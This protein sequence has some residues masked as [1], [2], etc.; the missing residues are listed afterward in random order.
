MS[1]PDNMAESHPAPGAP[2]ADMAIATPPKEAPP[3][4]IGGPIKRALFSSSPT[5]AHKTNA[6]TPST[7]EKCTTRESHLVIAR[8][9]CITD[10]SESIIANTIKVIGAEP[11]LEAFLTTSPLEMMPTALVKITAKKSLDS[12]KHNDLFL[13][14]EGL[15][16]TQAMLVMPK[17]ACVGTL[18]TLIVH[19][20]DVYQRIHSLTQCAGSC[21]AMVGLPWQKY[22]AG[23]FDTGTAGEFDI[24]FERSVD[25]HKD[26]LKWC[27]DAM[28]LG[29]T[30]WALPHVTNA[31]IMALRTEFISEEADP[32]DKDAQDQQF[33][34]FKQALR[35][36]LQAI[37]V[38]GP[39]RD[40][41]WAV[42]PTDK[43]V[44]LTARGVDL[45]RLPA[46]TKMEMKKLVSTE[47][48][49]ASFEV[50]VAPQAGIFNIKRGFR[51]DGE[52]L[53][54][55]LTELGDDV[56]MVIPRTEMDT[57][58]TGLLKLVLRIKLPAEKLI[59]KKL[60]ALCKD[61]RN[62]AAEVKGI[63]TKLASGAEVRIIWSGDLG[64]ARA[65]NGLNRVAAISAE[66]NTKS[67]EELKKLKGEL[68]KQIKL[69]ADTLVEQD[70]KFT[71]YTV[72]MQELMDKQAT[73]ITDMQN[74]HATAMGDMQRQMGENEAAHAKSLVDTEAAHVKALADTEESF[75]KQMGEMQQVMQQQQQMQLGFTAEAAQ[76][77]QA[78]HAFMGDVK[79][80]M[81]VQRAQ[82]KELKDGS[83]G[84]VEAALALARRQ[85]AV[86]REAMAMHARVTALVTLARAGLPTAAI[87]EAPDFGV[88]CGDDLLLGRDQEDGTISGIR[89]GGCEHAA[90]VTD[91]DVERDS[92]GPVGRATAN[93]RI[94][95]V[96]GATRDRA[97][98]EPLV[99]QGRK[100]TCCI[101]EGR[102]S[103]PGLGGSKV[104]PRVS[105]VAESQRHTASMG[106]LDD[107]PLGG[108]L[109]V[110]SMSMS[111]PLPTI[112]TR[113]AT[114]ALGTAH[115]DGHVKFGNAASSRRAFT[116]IHAMLVVL[117]LLVDRCDAYGST[118]TCCATVDLRWTLDD[119][120]LKCYDTVALQCYGARQGSWLMHTVGTMTQLS[121]S[122]KDIGDAF[123]NC[124]RGRGAMPE[125][126]PEPDVHRQYEPE[127]EPSPRWDSPNQQV[128]PR[129]RARP[130]TDSNGRRG[131]GPLACVWAPRLQR[132]PRPRWTAGMA[133]GIF[134]DSGSS[135]RR[136]RHRW[137]ISRKAWKR[138]MRA[139]RG[140]TVAEMFN[141]ALWNARE[142]H[143]DA[144]P[145]R[146]A[147]RAKALWIMRRLQEEDVDVCFLLEVM[148]SQEAFTAGTFG[149]RAMAK[150]I[151]YVVRWMVG[152]G[153]SQREQRQSGE[154]FTNGI[155]VLVKQAT[156]TIER[157]ARLEERVLGVWIKGR[158]TKEQLQ[159]RIAA[160]HGLHH[161]GASSFTNQL[162]ATYTWAADPSQTVKGCLVVGDFNYVA[163]EAWRSSHAM[164][165]ANDR[166]FRDYISQPGAEYVLPASQP[167]VVWTRKGGDAAE[168]SDSDGFG[169]ML[170]GAVTIGSECGW[171]R[172]T[173]VDFAFNSDGLAT[174]S[175]KPLSDHAWVTFSREIPQLA[176]RG[177][178][179]PRSAL[180]RG[181]I[182]AKDNYR[183]R[184][185]EGVAFE[186]LL[187]ARG[188]LH[189]TT[190]A[191]RSLRRVAE[192]AA[193]EARRR[194][195]EHPLETAHRWRRWLQEA[196]AARHR[197]LAPH[198]VRGG[199]FNY[200]S[201]LWLIRERFEGA[202]DDVCWSKI[203][204][205]CR[206]CWT[207]ANRRLVRRQQRD[208]KRLRELSLGIVEGKGSTDL[209]QVAMR[210]W[211][212]IRPQ[213][214][215]LAFDRFHRRDDVHNAPTL[216]AD[217][218]DAF[219]NSLAR[220]GDRLVE[221]LSSTPAII[222]AFKAFCKVFCPTYET[223]RGRDGG[224]WELSKELTFPVFLQVLKRVPRGKAVGYGGF[225]IEL[226]IHADREIQR[227]FYD[228]LM[229]DLRGGDF[230]PSWR[231]V[232]YVLLT[233][234]PPS[235]PALIS[236]RREIALMAQDMK[237]VMHM[238][239]ATAY[240]LITG[241]LRSEQCGWLPGYG[242]V[243]AG[244]PLAAVIQ[245]AQRLQQSVWILY[246]DLATF[247]PRIDREALTVAEL[248]VGLP[249]QVI[250]LVGQ[251]YGAGRAVAAEAV[252]C[253]FDTSIGLS[254][255]FRNHR[256]AL[257]GEVLSPDRAK[258]ILNSI[259]WAIKLHVHG[260]QLF[261]F[262][263]DE[264][265]CIRA[266][267][268]LAYADDWAGT[269][270]SEVDLKR[271]W[272]IWSVWVP[273]SGS[274]LGIKGKLK[275]VVTG[276][277]RDGQGRESDIPDPQLVT[278][279]GVRV[280]TLSRSEAYKHLGVLRAA[281]GGDEAAADSLKKQL[282]VA[283]GR[284]ARMHKPSRRDMILVS[285][286]LFQGLAG[287]K[288]S[289]VYYPFEWM[290]DI[291]KE[292]RRMF[293]KKAR[294]DA[295]TPV[296][297]L[298]E[299]GGGVAGGR[300]HLW[301][302]GCASFYVSFT[303]ALADAAD[304]SQRAAARSALALSLSRWGVQG[305]PRLFSWRH[306]TSALERHLRGRRRYLGETF[307]F[308]S[309]LLQ[310]D[311]PPG[312]NWRWVRSPASCDPLHEGRPHFRTLES[313][314]L[315]EPEQRGGLGIEP[316]P[317]LLDARI[318]AAGQLYAWGAMHEGSRL[319][320]FEEARRL[321]PWLTAGAR[322]EWDRTVAG[323]EERL[324]VGAVPER[325]A[326]RAWDQRGLCVGGGGVGLDGGERGTVRTDTES[327]HKLHGAIRQ[328]LGELKRG[329]APTPVDWESALRNA[330]PGI[331]GP[332]AEEWCVGGGD[333]Q[334]DARGGR[335]FCDIDCAEEPRGGEA[336]WLRRSDVDG[337]GFLEGWM[338]RACELRSQFS[339]DME[340]YLC[341]R[342][343]RRLDQQQ[344]AQLDPA[345]QIVARARLALGDVEVFSGDGNKRQATH[346]QLAAQRNLWEKL[347]TWSA[348]IKATRIYTLDGG[349]REVKTEGG[350]VKIATRAAIDH[351]G[352][353]M[354]GRICEE[355]VNEDNY[356]AELAA[357]LDAL[358][359]AT[360]RG[361]DERVIMVFDATSPVRAMLRFGRLSARARGDR[362]AAEL[363]EHFERLRRRVAALV[364]LWQTSHVG[365]PVNEWVD[366]MCD[367]FGVDDDYP[368]PRG[369]V[370]FSS[371]IFP[372][373]R[374]PAQA[375]AMSGM[376]RVV[377]QRL[378]GRVRDTIL[379]DPDENVKLFGVTPEAQQ[380]CDEIAA[381]RCQYVDQPYA[382]LR[383]R[384]VLAAEWCP[385]GCID[386]DGRWREIHPSAVARR[387]VLQLPRLA[388]LV[389]TR[390]GTQPGATCMVTSQ[391]Q[392]DLGGDVVRAGDVTGW[393][394]RWFAR[395]ECIPT[396][397]HFQFECTGAPLLAARKTYALAAVAARRCMVSLQKGREL[398]PHSQLDD[399][400]L[401]LHQGL[402]GWEAEAGATGSVA[403][404]QSLR[405]R[406]QRGVTEAW[407][408][409]LLRAVAAG[410]VRISGTGA[411]NSGRWRLS[412]TEMVLSGCHL[413]K[414]GKEHCAEGR[415]AFWGRLGDLRLL[416]KIFRS[417]SRALL[418]TTVRR[419]AA[420]RELRLAKEFVMQVTTGERRRLRKEVEKRRDE[421]GDEQ[422][423]NGPGEWLLLRAWVA[424]RLTLAQGLGRSGRRISHGPVRDSLCEKL[425]AASTGRQREVE[426][427]REGVA[428]LRAR[429][430]LA[431][432]RWLRAGGWTEFKRCLQREARICRNRALAAQREGMRRW[433]CLADGTRWAILTE[434]ET[435]ERFEFRHE[436]LRALLEVKQTLS[437]GEWKTLGISNLRLGHFIRVG[438]FFYGPEQAPSSHTLSGQ[439]AMDVG[440]VIR[441]E[442]E[443]RGDPQRVK[444]HRQ[445]VQRVRRAL[446]TL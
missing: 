173:V 187:S 238:V 266:I 331:K 287:F 234:P 202:G 136:R 271:A 402:R 311:K 251:I 107:I 18:A 421:V 340:G 178:E 131:G 363:L 121:T 50:Y 30:S 335:V 270:G 143:A 342:G 1:F 249:P 113:D 224:A 355:D 40:D 354:G 69:N 134:A 42:Y 339:F 242:T 19:M 157:H 265:G 161:S 306:L 257:M 24:S 241:R 281:M 291:E 53:E 72:R 176:L 215:S 418:H 302:I 142:F 346:V 370:E 186:D 150:K 100:G 236:E 87:D 123:W 223:L 391:E 406:I 296:C 34:E 313:I 90:H 261:G 446:P 120:T 220:E 434:A 280:P 85:S 171:W 300:R 366:V 164:L 324:D 192:Q 205:R 39:E 73:V 429:S 393:Q 84:Y 174:G 78:L 149:L 169:S 23:L 379:R 33:T 378:R 377:A 127:P 126:T 139:L 318:R 433:A 54:A 221:G 52:G 284:V 218:P 130:N 367:K 425:L 396:W 341:Y 183:D 216:A 438:L 151:G 48:L 356:I 51:E 104:W 405:N 440:E 297:L 182:R 392:L 56:L 255:S 305:D 194:L 92:T 390:L 420:L 383:G 226:L 145:A 122:C 316:A 94:G 413:Q 168:A 49:Q 250:E 403:Q 197:G 422:A 430:K 103:A 409:E 60:Q 361:T 350:I 386:H 437:A 357:Q 322:A 135:L 278:L 399:L 209:A 79:R 181:D 175:A 395:V 299:G 240:R 320:S 435:E 101:G 272:A 154:S 106:A 199:L 285:N 364:L 189:A 125:P 319:M 15:Q 102:S 376:C 76:L 165:N 167:L 256:G 109:C 112:K 389:A 283:I 254:A 227:A 5:A 380:I 177:E 82:I 275:T 243:D 253:Q 8:S 179:R 277:L 46:G 276:V 61:P 159:T 337:L 63:P 114:M 2:I 262:G 228:C 163:E 347:T 91:H 289:T 267:A 29:F 155:A 264:E 191:V 146:E 211:K 369:L 41:G 398:V 75:K 239:R 385:F 99:A 14:K 400:I 170:D 203:I 44:E 10:T 152:E 219:L 417:W 12:F 274:K 118:T 365:E 373:H 371:M 43:T 26:K 81:L 67:S 411:D 11:Q 184:V 428:A 401:L 273:I 7:T 214:T 93:N 326:N 351:E 16:N 180:P 88:H 201:R 140:N 25:R 345:V 222:E 116:R 97:C 307:M 432:R 387:R 206:R 352:R 394:G 17:S 230:P 208:D 200:H 312:E 344:L 32:K 292:W 115:R 298:Y 235:N 108:V 31:L 21:W 293:N 358:T 55:V 196:Y 252:E 441:I 263:E 315:F 204:K 382:D 423:S 124:V 212:A 360:A 334:A 6:S 407:E 314:P 290:E 303:R 269:F 258:I 323:I 190:E 119:G 348:R 13:M 80:E 414:L 45:L 27:A 162:Q 95:E 317:R 20:F 336:S 294:R 416:H 133:H 353:V 38:L 295:T 404:Q 282:R 210:A 4:L 62:D 374:G 148:G 248:L 58:A 330:F 244:L 158:G 98:G 246:V 309:S 137:H 372:D 329:V 86:L 368:I 68:E 260:V 286:G 47:E 327:E 245:Q 233:K 397:W 415:R 65:R 436:G 74:Q 132:S 381:R 426:R 57:E 172:R 147:S 198:E 332:S 77:T 96:R 419:V 237:L 427:A 153:G 304:T 35:D 28:A 232:I 105:D 410:A 412:L 156:C 279:D 229:A 59:E 445:E 310:G 362:L 213:R 328:A 144:C 160:V 117:A 225:S 3:I 388:S 268:S 444:R 66:T 141:V 22:I 325:E 384:R 301:A 338:E 359:D 288:C 308:I 128:P 424:W 129:I 375:Y 110:E 349:W 193:A 207:S 439:A 431:W 408:T 247:F 343:G 185:R 9:G 64:T 166:A 138:R 321:Y 71:A 36:A 443:P 83:A 37:G 195:E 442:I 217:D 70:S 259:L 111:I 89:A 188:M 333:I 231:K